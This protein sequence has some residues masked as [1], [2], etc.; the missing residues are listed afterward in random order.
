MRLAEKF[1]REIALEELPGLVGEELGV[2]EWVTVTQERVNAFA[3]ATG[4]HHGS[5][6]TWSAPGPR[7]AG[8]RPRLPDP[9]ADPH[10]LPVADERHGGEALRRPRLQQHPL[11]RHGAGRRPHP[12]APEAAHLRQAG[13][14]HTFISECR[15][16]VEGERRAACIAETVAMLYAD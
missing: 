16:E 14:G 8:H 5:T 6:S 9:V 11:P 1:T 15:I 12:P 4:D 2:S 10:A 7:S 3:D 13:R